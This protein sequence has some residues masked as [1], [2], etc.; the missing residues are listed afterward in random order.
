MK[1]VILGPLSYLWLAKITDGSTHKLGF[2]DDLITVYRELLG[3]LAKEAVEWVQF[4]EPI[5]ALDLPEQW[6]HAF[7]RVYHQ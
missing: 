7:E 1:P 3:T 2:L 6:Q 4:D 5:L